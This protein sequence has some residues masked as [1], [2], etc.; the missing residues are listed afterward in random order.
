MNREEGSADLVEEIEDGKVLHWGICLSTWWVWDL[1]RDDGNDHLES[2]S[3][4]PTHLL[5]L[6]WIAAWNSFPT[7]HGSQ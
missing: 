1:W 7:R 5:G 2:G 4:L 3:S 6:S